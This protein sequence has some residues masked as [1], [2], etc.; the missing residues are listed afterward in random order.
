MHLTARR[1]REKWVTLHFSIFTLSVF[2]FSS[3]PHVGR[4][5]IGTKSFDSASNAILSNDPTGYMTNHLVLHYFPAVILMQCLGFTM[6]DSQGKIPL[7]MSFMAWVK[8]CY[9]ENWKFSI[10]YLSLKHHTHNLVKMQ[11][12]QTWTEFCR[13]KVKMFNNIW[14]RMFSNLK[15]SR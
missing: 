9:F 7:L 6:D 14:L 8:S 15:L 10:N 12:L 5:T 1:D 11:I 13:K 3:C 2:A 4:P